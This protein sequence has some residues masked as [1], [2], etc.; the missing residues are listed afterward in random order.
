[1]DLDWDDDEEPRGDGRECPICYESLSEKDWTWVVYSRYCKE[2]A[3]PYLITKVQ[4]AIKNELYYP[5]REGR[6]DIHLPSLQQLIDDDALLRMYFH[7]GRDYAVPVPERKYC[8]HK[9]LVGDRPEDPY[10]YENRKTWIPPIAL[11]VETET[12]G[13]QLRAPTEDLLDCSSCSGLTCANC[14]KPIYGANVD[15]YC[16]MLEEADEEVDGFAGQVR[17]KEY[18][19]CPN[20]Q[21]QMPVSLWAACNHMVCAKPSCRTE[22]CFVCGERADESDGHW[23]THED[24]CP[25]YGQPD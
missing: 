18:Q 16:P 9:I 23:G 4:D 21:C 10:T 8:K 25:V 12:C 24:Q 1:M 14:I 6:D 17:G 5:V 20:E 3:K 13:F 7:R 15:H 11:E 2:C 19:I 22:F